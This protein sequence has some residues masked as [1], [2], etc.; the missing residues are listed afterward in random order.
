[1]KIPS[2]PDEKSWFLATAGIGWFRL[3]GFLVVISNGSHAVG[4]RRSA[5]QR[6]Y[7][8]NPPANKSGVTGSKYRAKKEAGAF[9]PARE[10]KFQ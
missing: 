4:A 8:F 7:R 3:S 10:F 6:Q 5:K 2:E 9:A 1:L